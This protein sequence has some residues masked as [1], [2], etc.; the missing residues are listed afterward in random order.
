MF[1]GVRV[2]GDA[3]RGVGV[4]WCVGGDGRSRALATVA[5]AGADST[6]GGDDPRG[7]A[8]RNDCGRRGVDSAGCGRELLALPVPDHGGLEMVGPEAYCTRATSVAISWLVLSSSS[9][10]IATLVRHRHGGGTRGW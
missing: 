1:I 6:G 10:S 3:R 9:S 7:L 2:L 4:R 8:A 5:M